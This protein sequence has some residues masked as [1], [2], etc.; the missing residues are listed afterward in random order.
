VA[1]GEP[2]YEQND[3]KGVRAV[4]GLGDEDALNQ[5][6]GSAETRAG[7]APAF[8]NILQQRVG[9]FRLADPSRPGHRKI[10]AFFLGDPAVTIT[11][12]SDVP[13]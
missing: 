4:Y 13:P 10:L 11:S 8:P 1:V 3:R 12:T 6:L 2:E 7:R 5:V 9:P